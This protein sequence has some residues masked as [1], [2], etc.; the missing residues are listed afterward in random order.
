MEDGHPYEFDIR[1]RRKDGS[2]RWLRSNG[3]GV[4]SSETGR[5]VRLVGTMQDI[6]KWHEAEEAQIRLAREAEKARDL[7]LAASRAKSTFLANMS[8]EIRT[9]MN[10]VLG[11]T[12][13][14]LDTDLSANQRDYAETVLRSG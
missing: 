5:V 1:T 3:R 2:L 12:E 11:M 14:L 10:G 9:P 6:T 8:H 4:R 7:A 13:I